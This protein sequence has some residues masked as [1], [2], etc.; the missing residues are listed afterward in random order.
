MFIVCNML[1][2]QLLN[3]IRLVLF[4]IAFDLTANSQPLRRRA[5]RTHPAKFIDEGVREALVQLE[6]IILKHILRKVY[7]VL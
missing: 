7:L 4:K 6:R 3:Q 2:V 1:S 5:K